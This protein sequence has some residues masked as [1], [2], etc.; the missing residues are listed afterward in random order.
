MIYFIQAADGT[1][2]IKIG[3]TEQ[4]FKRLSDIQTHS[5]IKLKILKVIEGDRVLE[6]SLHRRFVR[7]MT[8]GEWFLP[9]DTL[10]VTIN[11]FP[12]VEL[13]IPTTLEECCYITA[14]NYKCRRYAQNSSVY[15]KIHAKR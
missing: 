6:V 2:P 11:E 13:D 3:H 4:I 5:P 7:L 14:D 1:G 8:H 15:C 9:D 12:G 10:M